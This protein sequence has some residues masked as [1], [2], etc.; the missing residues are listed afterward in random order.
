V[1]LNS[2]G[3]F[4]YT[5]TAGYAG[6]DSFTYEANNGLADSNVATVTLNPDYPPQAQDDTYTLPANS[7]FTAGAGGTFLTMDSQPGEYIGQGQPYFYTPANSTFTATAFA[8]AVQVQVTQSGESWMLDFQA[9]NSGRLVPGLYP[10]AVAWPSQT[11]GSPGLSVSGFGRGFSTI[12]GQ[13]TVTQAVYDPSG[14]II[15]FAASF[16]Q[17]ADGSSSALTGQ[18]AFD[19]TNPLAG[20][21]L[22]NDTDPNA[23]TT[24]TATLVSNPAHGTVVFNPDGSFS[25]APAPG[26][27]GTDSFTYQ[28]NDGSFFS[29]VASVT[30]TVASPVANNDSYSTDQNTVLSVA[31]LGVLA[32]D[33]DPHNLPLT[34]VLVAHP[35]HGTLALG[36]DGSFTYTPAANFLGT[37]SFTYQAS[38][39]QDLSAVATVT[40]EVMPPSSAT[41]IK[42]DTT[43]EGTWIGT[44]GTQ[45]YDIVGRPADLPL[46]DTITPSGQSTLAWSHA[47]DDPRALQFPHGSRRIAEAWY[48]ATSFQVDVNLADGQSHDLEL[49]FLD[50]DSDSRAE[51]VQVTDYV[52]GAVLSTQTVSSFHSG[53]YLDYLVGGTGHIVITITRTGGANAVLS[54]LFLDPA[55]GGAPSVADRR[56]DTSVGRLAPQTGTVGGPM[57]PG[58]FVGAASTVGLAAAPGISSAGPAGPGPRGAAVVD[59][60]G[61]PTGRPAVPVAARGP[62]PDGSLLIAASRRLARRPVGMVRQPR[63]DDRS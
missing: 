8:N 4:T 13:F 39:G 46:H 27:M 17:Y 47:T 49:Y 59:R 1:T 24:L 63:F 57:V 2:D 55:T 9:P 62:L 16:V 25:Y 37:D 30:L 6:A 36:A 40:I 54:G 5:P 42:T 18:V 26:F 7:T 29:N 23:G 44:Y 31:A 58:D 21:V 15:S 35:A 19:C 53:V 61:K 41:L 34:A 48:S 56:S 51:Q 38:D 32:N 50:W 14:N 33:T 43:T 60:T 22:A 52:T 11:T 20:G 12:T 3:S 28:A 45:G 10:A